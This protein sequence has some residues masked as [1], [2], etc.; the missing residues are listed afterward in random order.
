MYALRALL[1]ALSPI[2][3]FESENGSAPGKGWSKE[4]SD[5][6]IKEWK[7]KG[8]EL[9]SELKTEIETVFENEYWHLYRRVNNQ[10]FSNSTEAD[11]LVAPRF[12]G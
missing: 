11:T 9:D 8:L 12:E 7:E 5:E 2:I 1:N 4:I 10:L 6:K 3:G